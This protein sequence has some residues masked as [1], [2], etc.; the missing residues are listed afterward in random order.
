M[1]VYYIR[2]MDFECQ[3][4][5]Y[6]KLQCKSIKQLLKE[7]KLYLNVHHALG[8]AAQV[9]LICDFY[10]CAFT[11]NS[12]MSNREFQTHTISCTLFSIGWWHFTWSCSVL[13]YLKQNRNQPFLCSPMLPILPSCSRGTKTQW[14]WGQQLKTVNGSPRVLPIIEKV[15]MLH[16]HSSLNVKRLSLCLLRA[17]SPTFWTVAQECTLQAMERAT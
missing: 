13:F 4:L 1:A 6:I 11:C 9:P 10:F 2:K 5:S 16:P 17:F 12:K 8:Y 3:K 7:Y 15:C 14:Q